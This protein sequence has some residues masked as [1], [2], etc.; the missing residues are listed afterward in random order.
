MSSIAPI[1]VRV[2]DLN[3]AAAACE[4]VLALLHEHDA[5][6]ESVYSVSRALLAR[7]L[8]TWNT[9]R[10][11]D[12]HG[13]HHWV[14]DGDTL[15]RTQ[16]DAHIQLLWLLQDQSEMETRARDYWDY[17]WIERF[18]LRRIIDR[19]TEPIARGIATWPDRADS[20]PAQDQ[21]LRT[22]G[23]R[24]LTDK[25]LKEFRAQGE[26]YLLHPTC[27]YRET[28]YSPL[29]LR[30]LAEQVGI[31]AEHEFFIQMGH[32]AVHSTPLMVLDATG[33]VRRAHSLIAMRFALRAANRAARALSLPLSA[34]DA[35]WLGKGE[36]SILS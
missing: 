28:W 27:R 16:Y 13:R 11:L 21:L 26:A 8:D 6:P 29:E 10:V 32:K 19:S 33:M 2:E 34:V 5:R 20:E 30:Q 12:E 17:Q 36:P 4:A 3:D 22:I 1:H 24:F 25:G 23:E 7:I 31:K 9:I 35:N 18:R 14:W 15:L